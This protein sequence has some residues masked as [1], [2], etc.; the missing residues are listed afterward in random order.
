[1]ASTVD[2]HRLIQFQTLLVEALHRGWYPLTPAESVSTA[3]YLAVLTHLERLL[4][5]RYRAHAW[6]RAFRGPVANPVWEPSWLSSPDRALEMLPVTDR[7]ALM[8]LLAWWLDHWPEQ[9][10]ALCAMAQ[11]TPADLRSGFLD[12]PAWYEAAVAQVTQSRCA[13]MKLVSYRAVSA[14]LAAASATPHPR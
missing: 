9:F 6:R 7:F 8:R 12:P 11:L 10:V 4:L 1:M 13:G 5:R 3:E 2:R 14:V